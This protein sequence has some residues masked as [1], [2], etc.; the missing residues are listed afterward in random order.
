M[1]KPFKCKKQSDL[2]SHLGISTNSPTY[3]KVT[4]LKRFGWFTELLRLAILGYNMEKL[5]KH[6]S[7][8]E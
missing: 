2:F 4:R 5:S 8:E 6:L 7:E 3:Q 1:K